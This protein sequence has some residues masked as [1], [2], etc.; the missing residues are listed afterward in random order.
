[1]AAVA[2]AADGPPGRRQLGVDLLAIDTGLAAA[3]ET[4]VESRGGRV[5]RFQ[6][7][8][9]FVQALM[10][11]LPKLLLVPAPVLPQA[12]E[13][14]DK[15]VAREPQLAALRL[16]ACGDDDV[17]LASVLAGADGWLLSSEPAAFA[18]QVVA[19][20]LRPATLPTRLLVIDAE[21]ESRSRLVAGLTALGIAVEA[22]DDP[23]LA[24]SQL[25]ARRPEAVLAALTLPGL[26]GLALTERLRNTAVAAT[27]PIIL[28]AAEDSTSARMAALRCGADGLLT[29]PVRLRELVAV[30]GGQVRRPQGAG[31]AAD[32][33]A[34][35][36]RRPRGEFLAELQHRGGVAAEGWEL[37]LALR[38]DQADLRKRLGLSAAYALE[39]ELAERIRPQL[40]PTDCYSLWEEFGYGLLLRRGSEPEV[41]ATLGDLLRAV[42][43]Q[44][45]QV[46]DETLPLSVSIGYALPPREGR[47]DLGD[48]W[49]ASSFAALAMAQRLG[50]GRAEGM[51]SRDPH[52]LPPERVMVIQQAL[53]DLGR[54]GSL[55]FEFQAL[56]GLRDERRHFA[57]SARL[58]DLRS[59]L[60][61]YPRQEY[62]ELARAE[63]QLA[64]IDR[65]GLFHAL[66][67]ITELQQEG[68]EVC[69]LAAFDLAA[70]DE[71]QLAWLEAE[72]R[73]RSGMAAAL[74]LDLDAEQVLDPLHAE[75]IA[76]LRQAGLTL[77]AGGAAVEPLLA[78]LAGQ[79]VQ[80]LR[81]P[82]AQIS[83]FPDA[84]LRELFRRWQALDR[85]L[86][87]EQVESMQA[88]GSLWSLGIDYLQGDALAGATPRPDIDSARDR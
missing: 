34:L 19:E 87:I 1:M 28:L 4:A 83:R 22:L 45:F 9:A 12:V 53:R 2:T 76:R 57:L 46:A 84:E 82:H 40:Q 16:L 8:D 48:R 49:I 13:L 55:R 60:S 74:M 78:A 6:R 36:L 37:L 69:V 25:E 70:S 41:E 15:L 32:P 86:L 21:S 88:V 24:L 61:G 27:L 3:V 64:T 29:T 31:T 51:L 20:L 77:A 65:M 7:A 38:V 59:P 23:R 81:L 18:D 71:R 85:R 56:A 17:R 75:Q 54:G 66:E 73:R 47:G 72:L 11:G 44:P 39:R 58:R 62:R 33:A 26:D 68:L 52:A 43:G 80:L 35:G 67:T 10:Q 50:G 63:G 30:L 79:P 14:L 42:A 5:R